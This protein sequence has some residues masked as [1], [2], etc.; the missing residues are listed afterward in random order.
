MRTMSDSMYLVEKGIACLEGGG[1]RGARGARVGKS[2]GKGGGLR[3][4][5]VVGH[6]SLKYAQRGQIVTVK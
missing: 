2:G 1:G 5:G 6:P 4:R 3:E